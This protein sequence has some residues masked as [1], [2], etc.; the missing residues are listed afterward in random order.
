MNYRAV[1]RGRQL[2]ARHYCFQIKTQ[3][4]RKRETH[5]HK[6]RKEKKRRKTK[7]KEKEKKEGKAEKKETRIVELPKTNGR[8]KAFANY[9]HKPIQVLM[10]GK[11]ERDGE[12]GRR[13]GKKI[14]R[15]RKRKRKIS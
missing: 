10:R 7:E 13:K 2:L 3:R 9:G 6:E 8:P 15:N 14:E 12:K 5:T 1:G 4:E 11:E